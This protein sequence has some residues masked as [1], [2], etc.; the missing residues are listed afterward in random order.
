MQTEQVDVVIE[1]DEPQHGDDP[2]VEPG[3]VGNVDLPIVDPVGRGIELAVAGQ[4]GL[5]D[6]TGALGVAAGRGG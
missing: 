2:L 5:V 6:D 3:G 1:L 4:P